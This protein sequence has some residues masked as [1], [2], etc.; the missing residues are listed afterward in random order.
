MV[1]GADQSE[2]FIECEEGKIEDE[3][4]GKKVNVSEI[5]KRERKEKKKT[6]L[7]KGKDRGR[8]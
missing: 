4:K 7:A 5:E 6:R 2:S 3:K 1:V 8:M